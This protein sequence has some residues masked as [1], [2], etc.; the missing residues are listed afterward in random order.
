LPNSFYKKTGREMNINYSI[1]PTHLIYQ[2]TMLFALLSTSTI[3]ISYIFF[4]SRMRGAWKIITL[5]F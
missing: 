3:L 2:P 4:A 1:T 5:V